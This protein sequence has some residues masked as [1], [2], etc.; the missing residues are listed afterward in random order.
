MLV[1]L[2]WL[3]EYLELPGAGFGDPEGLAHRLTMASAEVE[4]IHRL[5][6]WDRDLV[7]VGEVLAVDPHPNADRL[8]L[9]TVNY[10]GDAPQQVVCGAPNL[11][12]G[13][14]IAFGR[15]GAVLLDGHTGDSITLK[16][17]KI[18]GVE[19]SG[20]VLSERELGLSEAHEGIIELPSDAPIG[21]PLADY[22]GDVVLDVHVWPNRADTMNMVGIAR[23]IAAIEGG[24][25]REPDVSYAEA[26]APVAD[27]VTVRIEDPELCARY[28]AILVE[29][30]S[31]GPSPQWM[32]ERLRAAGQRPIS[33]VV[34]VTN[35]VMLELGQP[36]HAFDFDSVEGAI[37]VRRARAGERLVTLD[38]E[39]RV[40]RAD[41][42][43]IADE[44]EG[45]RPIALA[46]VMGGLDSEVTESTSRVLLEAASF[47]P[48][49]IRRTSTRLRLRSEA[50]SRFERGL[51]PELPLL[52]AQ[53]AAQLLAEVCGGTVRPGMVDAYPSPFVAAAVDV[54][55]ARMDTLI[56]IEVPDAEVRGILETLGFDVEPL[57]DG[58]R[59]TPPWWRT[60]VSIADDVI[61]EVVRIAGYDR[62]PATTL[63]GRVPP[64]EPAPFVEL[65]EQLKDALVDAG[66]QE[67]ITY[68]LTTDEV[69][70]RVMAPEDLAIVRPL[71]LRNTLSSD[72]E[73]L[74]PTLRHAVLE[75]VDRNIRAGA[76]SIAVFEA[77]R[78]FL[79]RHD[80]AS[81]GSEALPEEREVIVGALSGVDLDRWGRPGERAL[82]FFDGKG[83][84]DA[85]LGALGVDVEYVAGEEFGLLPGRVAHLVVS[86][87]A[88]AGASEGGRV[89]VI[90][91]VHPGTLAQFEI[92]QP[93]VLFELDVPALLPHVPARRGIASVSR[94]P[95]VEQDL[96]V[97]VDASVPASAL[98]RAIESSALVSEAQ[99][100]D[101]YRGEQVGAGKKSVAVSI[102]YQASDR[103]LTTE[104]ANREQ[105]RILRRL[106]HELGAEARG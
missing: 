46:G 14:R 66:M 50:S 101:V 40:L 96:A 85:A 71:R 99:V 88:S 10:G 31:L 3:R 60:D 44:G 8:R 36:L 103:T 80:G 48:A 4:G 73:V 19:S 76:A 93:V 82:D 79:P 87:G 70:S 49:S 39:E 104:D 33:N 47:A 34:D 42:L 67:T 51:S 45:G 37:V 72:R 69:L 20:M 55:R 53:R 81:D 59:V 11:A 27:D 1:S 54:P 9:A 89:G 58:Y 77:A 57:A 6:G 84:L 75:T 30:V 95:A 61:E 78:A 22:L 7:T 74:R 56:G 94:F 41:T 16:R 24:T 15:E 86:A 90:G 29:G 35:Y 17:A 102:R 100:F 18:R 28:I 5:G 32:Q 105:A 38:G 63:A 91:E 64:R 62:L 98:V 12:V 13:Q 43:V 83:V 23:E 21:M 97:V 65:R 106:E 68:S 2:K 92:E 25:L 26:G 52:A